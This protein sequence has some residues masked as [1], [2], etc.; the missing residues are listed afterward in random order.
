MNVAE[1]LLEL[2]PEGVVLLGWPSGSKGTEIPWGHLTAADMAPAYLKKLDGGNIG[3]AFGKVSN[4]T[5]G[6]DIDDD[7]FVEPFLKVNPW[8]KDTLQTHGARGRVF[9]LQMAGSYPPR[10]SSSN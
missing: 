8:L 2:L 6:I 4:D 7:D 10:R 9:W 3:V 1:S 5:V